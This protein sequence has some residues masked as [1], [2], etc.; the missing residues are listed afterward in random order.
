MP[1][2]IHR[3]NKS[4]DTEYPVFE[5]M[6]VWNFAE[7][8]SNIENERVS[9]CR[10]PTGLTG[11]TGPTGPTG[12]IGAEGISGA[13]GETGPTGE[14]G[15]TGATGPTG[16]AGPTGE[17]GATGPI[18]PAAPVSNML[19]LATFQ[20]IIDGDWV[21]LGS[22]SAET[23]F[24]RSTVVIPMTSLIA[25]LVLNIRDNELKE[26]EAVT[27]TVFT[28][29]CG[30]SAPVST[31]ISVTVTGPNPPNCSATALGFAQISPGNLLSVKITATAG[32]EVLNSGVSVTVLLTI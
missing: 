24:L 28:S 12:P 6:K 30:F 26:D 32:V 1:Y 2:N 14:T 5:K 10:G 27:A 4:S 15:A 11:A 19:F 7:K 16:A 8:N 9:N 20:P 31:G 29:S 3:T 18:G 21:G 22:S 23:Q 17:A 25:G 13:S